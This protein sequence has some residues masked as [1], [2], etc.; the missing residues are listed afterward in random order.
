[1]PS[2]LVRAEMRMG[3]RKKNGATFLTC[4]VTDS[5]SKPEVRVVESLLASTAWRSGLFWLVSVLVQLS[6]VNNCFN[7]TEDRER[8]VGY[9]AD[10][11]F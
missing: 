4:P 2:V 6:V 9:S 1:M 5:S 10:M 8:D 7:S 3:F 11:T